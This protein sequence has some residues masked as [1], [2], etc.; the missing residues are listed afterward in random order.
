MQEHEVDG[1]VHDGRR[2]EGPDEAGERTLP[3]RAHVPAEREEGAAGEVGA[4]RVH[5][6]VEQPLD[7]GRPAP[8]AEQRAAADEH[9]A[10]GAAEHN[11]GQ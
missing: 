7:D 4:E 11:G 9:R 3:G 2:G 6:R 1:D 8:Y 5:A 10:D